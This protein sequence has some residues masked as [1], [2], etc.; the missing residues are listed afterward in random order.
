MT[1][2]KTIHSQYLNAL[3]MQ[4]HFWSVSNFEHINFAIN[5][6][7]SKF[8]Y[9]NSYYYAY[10]VIFQTYKKVVL[11]SVHLFGWFLWLCFYPYVILLISY[12]D[13]KK[14]KKKRE[15]NQQ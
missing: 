12:E 13:E 6:K 10:F 14:F 3:N 9:Y 1:K 7:Y 5:E 2:I 8:F 15:N 11:K 4:R